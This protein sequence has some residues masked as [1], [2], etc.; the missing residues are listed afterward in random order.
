MYLEIVHEESEASE[1]Y[2]WDLGAYGVPMHIFRNKN[3]ELFIRYASLHWRLHADFPIKCHRLCFVLCKHP[4]ASRPE[5][6]D[7]RNIR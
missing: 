5:M 6:M 4:H 7:A 1:P 3:P 2:R